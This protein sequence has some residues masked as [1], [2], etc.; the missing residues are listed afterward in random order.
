MKFV[1]LLIFGFV[2]FAAGYLI[3]PREEMPISGPPPRVLSFAGYFKDAERVLVSYN[4][5]NKP[6]K[7]VALELAP[8]EGELLEKALSADLAA[9]PGEG[10]LSYPDR[11]KI[12]V[13]GPAG[14]VCYDYQA[15]AGAARISMVDGPEDRLLS[16]SGFSAELL[17]LIHLRDKP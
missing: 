14:M 13:A 8:G 6:S 16:A 11:F 4:L 7:S 5:G 15:T 3:A 10:R 12:T 2:C 17:K 9:G 1:W